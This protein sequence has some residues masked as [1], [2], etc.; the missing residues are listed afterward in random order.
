MTTPTIP[1]RTSLR[2]SA[3]MAA[4]AVAVAACAPVTPSQPRAMLMAYPTLTGLEQVRDA[5]TGSD[6]FVPCNPCT[7]PTAKTPVLGTYTT[8]SI[9]GARVSQQQQP[10]RPVAGDAN[11]LSFATP[12]SPAG[13]PAATAVSSSI[14]AALPSPAPLVTRTPDARPSASIAK[15][16]IQFA[17]ASTSL[18]A[19]AR[20]LIAELN[21]RAMKAKRIY[22]RGRTDAI[23]SAAANRAIA[24]A[25]A[26]AVHREF[27]TAGVP[28]NKLNVFYCSNCYVAS[29]DTEWGRAAN[30]RVEIEVLDRGSS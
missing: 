18:S 16:S 9:D 5:R 6:Y 4:L 3:G 11:A 21:P 2:A 10:P 28:A 29:N 15:E 23:G 14:R 19:A 20:Q 12:A 30:R 1:S 24:L 27:L 7:A 25:R 26:Q 22:I 8:A 17:S 13:Q